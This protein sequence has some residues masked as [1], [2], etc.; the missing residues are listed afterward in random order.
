MLPAE[1]FGCIVGVKLSQAIYYV[2]SMD[3]V[4]ETL[5]SLAKV[6]RH[7]PLNMQQHQRL[8]LQQHQQ[9][10]LRRRSQH[11][12]RFLAGSNGGLL[13]HHRRHTGSHGALH[14]VATSK[15][16][17]TLGGP[18]STPASRSSSPRLQGATGE[19]TAGLHSGLLPRLRTRTPSPRVLEF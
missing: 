3:K 13:L 18:S 15:S 12:Q 8:L 19:R 9:H 11:Q 17:P 16:A 7:L 6:T 10:L 1:S 14:D 2:R 5:E 4:L